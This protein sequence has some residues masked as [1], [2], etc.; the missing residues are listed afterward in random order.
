MRALLLSILAVFLLSVPNAAAHTYLEKTN[1]EDSAT[2][3]TELDKITLTYSGKIE[4]GSTFTVTAS[5]GSEIALQAV[6]LNNGVLTGQLAAPIANDTYT[7]NWSS[8]SADGHSLTGTFSFIVNAPVVAAE[9]VEP[10]VTP[11]ETT[12]PVREV[13]TDTKEDSSSAMPLIIV[14]VLLLAVIIV[15]LL[16]LL[17]RKKTK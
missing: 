5:D 16:T 17:K 3:T 7:V 4:E 10:E 12:E 8:I 13:A 2:V 1:P 14:G 11:T 6:T 9:T 15:S